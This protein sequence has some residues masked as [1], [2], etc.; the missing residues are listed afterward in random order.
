MDWLK[1][2]FLYDIWC[3]LMDHLGFMGATAFVYIGFAFT[4]CFTIWY[5]TKVMFHYYEDM[6]S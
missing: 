3:W 4:L 1:D 5:V 2:I 6:K